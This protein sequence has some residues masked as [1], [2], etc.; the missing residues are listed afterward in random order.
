[1]QLNKRQRLV[2]LGVLQDEQDIM[3]L[4]VSGNLGLSREQ[5]GRRRIQVRNA[6]AGMVPMNLAG[7]IGHVP[8]NSECVLYHREYLRLEDM[9]LLQ[10]CNFWGGRRTSHLKLTETGRRVAQQVLAEEADA[11]GDM[12]LDWSG[13]LST[14]ELAP[15]PHEAN[16]AQ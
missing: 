6:Q 2:L 14:I 12:E 7:W 3:N 16:N 11:L 15:E 1:M 10:R 13:L 5:I 9:G 8:S 4:P